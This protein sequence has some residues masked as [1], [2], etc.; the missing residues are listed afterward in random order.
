MEIQVKKTNITY[1]L[2]ELP[3]NEIRLKFGISEF[4]VT[5]TQLVELFNLL[6]NS[7]YCLESSFRKKSENFL[8]SKKDIGAISLYFREA[9]HLISEATFFNLLSLLTHYYSI[10]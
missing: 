6:S 5:E 1:L 7:E 3:N 10:E 4:L 9:E 8:L 2:K